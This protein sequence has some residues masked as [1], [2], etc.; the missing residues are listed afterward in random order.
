VEA[1]ASGV[2]EDFNGK[3]EKNR[4]ITND[5]T[6][7]FINLKEVHLVEDVEISFKYYFYEHFLIEI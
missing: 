4:R 5:N 1:A 7:Y 2:G 3:A 6:K